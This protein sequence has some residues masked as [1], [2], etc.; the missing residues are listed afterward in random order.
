MS[1][2][3][4]NLR[5]GS[6]ELA[7]WGA[8]NKDNIIFGVLIIL[9]FSIILPIL[10]HLFVGLIKKLLKKQKL[11]IA[12]IQRK[13]EFP[14]Y[15]LLVFTGLYI[16]CKTMKFPPKIDSFLDVLYKIILICIFSWILSNLSSYVV[17]PL[18]KNTSVMSETTV[19]F[20]SNFLK[21]IIIIIATVMIISELG[22]N[23]N[24]IITGLGLGGLT[25]SLAAKSTAQNFF[26]SFS[27]ASDQPFAI[28]DL[29]KTSFIE[30]T[31]EDINMKSTK[32]RTNYGTLATVPNSMLSENVI[33]NL[34]RFN[35]RQVQKDIVVN[36]ETPHEILEQA[37]SK[38][39]EAI[40]STKS[41]E[42]ISVCVAGFDENGI[43]IGIIY[44]ITEKSTDEYLNLQSEINLKIKDVLE[45]FEIKQSKTVV[46]INSKQ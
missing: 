5:M 33:I 34:S 18:L 26:A 40:S 38:I 19:V 14:I 4:K 20:A 2:L 44:Y 27:I 39:K 15:S 6:N 35:H 21:I 43:K 29:I 7:L 25:L 24:G 30:G 36:R 42:D 1:G 45:K 12:G 41:T 16:G 31:V 9:I 8:K 23:I 32:I 28:G 3:L 11:G 46:D 17:R 13:I 22:Y 37:I 10:L